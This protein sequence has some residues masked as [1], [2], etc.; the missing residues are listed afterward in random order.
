MVI[1]DVPLIVSDPVGTIVAEYAALSPL[2][3]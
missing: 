2:I 3:R 1:E